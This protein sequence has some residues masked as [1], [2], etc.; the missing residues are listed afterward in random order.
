MI[1]DLP[2]AEVFVTASGDGAS[3]WA[4]RVDLSAGSADTTL[5][6]AL[7]GWINVSVVD[8]SG[9]AIEGAQVS[10][11]L[12]K[13]GARFVRTD[14]TD[15]AGT[16]R[17][18]GL[19]SGDYEIAAARPGITGASRDPKVIGHTG[20]SVQ[21]VLGAIGSIKGQVRFGDGSSPS[22]VTIRLDGNGARHVFPDGDIAIADVAPGSYSLRIEGPEIASTP[23]TNALVD[24]GRTTD[25]GTIQAERGRSIDGLVIDKEGQP[26]AGA[27]VVAGNVMVGTGSTVDSGSRAP[28][29]Q[30]ELKR[31][32]TDADGRFTLRG[33]AATS[34]SIVA[35]H[36]K[37]GRSSPLTL[38]ADATEPLRIMLTPTSSLSRTVSAEGHPTPA[39]VIAQPAA[40]PLALSVVFAGADGTFRFDNLAAGRY[41]VAAATGDPLA[42]MP[43]SPVTIDVATGGA[44]HVDL[45]AFRGSRS[46]AVST[47]ARGIAWV[48]TEAVRPK[49]ALEL[50]TQLGQQTRGHWAMAPSD[51]NARFSLLAPKAYTACAARFNASVKDLSEMLHAITVAGSAMPVTCRSVS[52]TA[53][54]VALDQKDAL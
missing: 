41:S 40:S 38:P 49:T 51:G 14:M 18:A 21:L 31:A 29:F 27:E 1:D 4:K 45:Q 22:T 35:S 48:T 19:P 36:A 2:R 23:V 32:T 44:A 11:S 28:T 15:G 3:C 39:T 33:I 46:L 25:L 37:A 47:A 52:S 9:A 50:I 6:L 10:I 30:A 12:I 53:T 54:S 24:D 13:D 34:V 5:T 26:V 7:E 20:K 16:F 17:F 42:G 43:L 8:R